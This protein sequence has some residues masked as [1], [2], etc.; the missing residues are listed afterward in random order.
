MGLAPALTPAQQA[1]QRLKDLNKAHDEQIQQLDE[2]AAQLKAQMDGR[3]ELFSWTQKDLD[4][5]GAR[6]LILAH[7]LDLER[8][9]TAETIARIKAQQDLF[10]QLASGKIPGLPDGILPPGFTFPGGSS[11]TIGTANI[12]IQ[13]PK[14]PTD[15]NEFMRMLG[16]AFAEMPLRRG[17]GY[18]R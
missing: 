18:E 12:T 17:L 7:Q 3:I 11:Y 2:Q 15:K 8:S 5:T 9:I 1:A 13:F 16:E 14:T 10:G 4:A 6:A